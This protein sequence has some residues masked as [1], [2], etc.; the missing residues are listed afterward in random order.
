MFMFELDF[1]FSG[2]E[3]IDVTLSS[4]SPTVEGLA[5]SR[6][7][8]LGTLSKEIIRSNWLTIQVLFSTPTVHANAVYTTV[9]RGLEMHRL[10]VVSVIEP[11]RLD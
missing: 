3:K 8:F 11:A 9:I 6:E 5:A 2:R 4:F 7:Y 10:T 1:G